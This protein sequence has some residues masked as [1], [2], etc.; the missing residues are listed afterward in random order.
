[1]FVSISER[2]FRSFYFNTKYRKLFLK[3]QNLK[4]VNFVQ[5][6]PVECLREKHKNCVEHYYMEL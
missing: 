5:N 2:M 4:I 3:V 6:H 1:M